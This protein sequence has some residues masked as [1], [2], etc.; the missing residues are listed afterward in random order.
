ML[1][2]S[3]LKMMIASIAIA[4]MLAVYAATASFASQGVA[5]QALPQLQYADAASVDYFL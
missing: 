5:D 4:S 2:P 1:H 3:R